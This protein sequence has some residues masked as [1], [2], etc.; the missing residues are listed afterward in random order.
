MHRNLLGIC[1]VVALGACTTAP[2]TS[3][4]TPEESSLA[5]I[6][7]G[8]TQVEVGAIL[9]DFQREDFDPS[10]SISSCRSYAYGLSPNMKYIHV[11]FYEEVVEEASDG[12]V[13]LCIY[14]GDIIG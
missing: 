13:G 8:M 2:L 6:K 7:Q 3:V 5:L 9:G 11:W 12:H 10:N 4:E 1:S 14:A